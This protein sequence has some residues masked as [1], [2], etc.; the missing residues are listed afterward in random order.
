MKETVP[1]TL[2]FTITC[3]VLLYVLF[4]DEMYPWYPKSYVEVLVLQN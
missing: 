4:M 1:P 2:K 3:Q